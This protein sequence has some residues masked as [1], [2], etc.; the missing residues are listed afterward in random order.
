MILTR[1]LLF[2]L[3]GLITGSTGVKVHIYVG[4][5]LNCT[6]AQS[7]CTAYSSLSVVSGRDDL[8]K[9]GEAAGG[10][11]GYS[12]IYNQQSSC[13]LLSVEDTIMDTST[14]AVGY[15]FNSPSDCSK[16]YFGSWTQVSCSDKHPF[17]CYE[18]FILV[19][20]NKTWEEALVY[21][22]TNYTD[23]VYLNFPWP[24]NQ[25]KDMT[26]KS[27]TDS[28]WTGLRFL[29]GAWNWLNMANVLAS[30]LSLPSCA[31]EPYRCG[32]RNIRTEQWENRDCEEKLN[33][34]CLKK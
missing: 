6:F 26:S 34:I 23:L 15:L 32:A 8:L 29:N 9:L 19:Q 22:R 13:R 2:V 5:P 31:P 17:F 7:H 3:Y 24:V 11:Y 33:F 4:T 27:Q 16:T 25:V 20:E 10:T 18:Q 14:S 21:C 1:L 12:W 28:V 30:N